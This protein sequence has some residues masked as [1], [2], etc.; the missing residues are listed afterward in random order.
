MCVRSLNKLYIPVLV[1]FT[2]I[3]VFLPLHKN[4]MYQAK[5][6]IAKCEEWEVDWLLADRHPL[7]SVGVVLHTSGVKTKFQW[8]T[9]SVCVCV[10]VC[11]RAHGTVTYKQPPQSCTVQVYCSEQWQ[12]VV[13]C[14]GTYWSHPHRQAKPYICQHTCTCIYNVLNLLPHYIAAFTY[15]W[16]IHLVKQSHTS[17]S[18][19][20]SR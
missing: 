12:D 20:K 8:E 17:L 18:S 4:I 9:C 13:M 3:H 5:S 11:A 14:S 16:H 19:M 6:S 2:D 10:C 1:P 15:A 7:W